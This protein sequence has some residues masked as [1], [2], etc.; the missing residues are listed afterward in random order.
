MESTQIVEAL[1][2]VAPDGAVEVAA[3]ADGMPAIYVAREHVVDVCLALRDRPE[4]GFSFAADIT[5]VDYL[6]REPR[7]EVMLH[8]VS[9]G[10]P[11]Y[12]DVAKRL[13]VKVKVPGTDP[14][15]PTLSGVW[16]AMNWGEREVYD[17]FG[18]KFDGHPDL[19]RILM[20]EDWEGHPARKDYPVQINMKAKMYEP[21]QLTPQEFAANLQADRARAK[22]AGQ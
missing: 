13:R 3:A 11:P 18:I 6:P 14:R 21:M 17:L 9:L 19:R 12:G 16:K 2:G 15:M 8:L 5:G 22:G 10:I 4:L 20:P 7:F 1:R